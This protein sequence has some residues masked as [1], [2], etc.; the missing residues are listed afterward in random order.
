MERSRRESPHQVDGVVTPL[1]QCFLP[2]ATTG[3]CLS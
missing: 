2:E 3:I 1:I